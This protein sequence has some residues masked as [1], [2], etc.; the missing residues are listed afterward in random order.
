MLL[1]YLAFKAGDA[2]RLKEYAGEAINRDPN[3]LGALVNGGAHLLRRR[4]HLAAANRNG[5]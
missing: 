5:A 1:G 4:V 2:A 3:E